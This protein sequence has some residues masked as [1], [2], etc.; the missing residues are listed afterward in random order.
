MSIGADFGNETL[1]ETILHVRQ[2]RGCARGG[3]VACAMET[4]TINA[5]IENSS[6]EVHRD[7]FAHV[8]PD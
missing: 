1:T 6:T 7:A 5:E 8:E 4:R 2:R 3:H